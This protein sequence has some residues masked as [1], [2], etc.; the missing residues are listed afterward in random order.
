MCETGPEGEDGKD[1]KDGSI[2]YHGEG[3]P[4]DSLDDVYLF[5]LWINEDN[6]LVSSRL[7][8][9]ETA[10]IT[11]Y[12]WFTS[13]SGETLPYDHNLINGFIYDDLNVYPS[14]SIDNEEV[15]KQDYYETE[16]YKPTKE[17]MDYI[18]KGKILD[19]FYGLRD[20]SFLKQYYPEYFGDESSN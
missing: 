8:V 20:Y 2:F 1:G 15:H 17:E 18:F 3:K 6:P 4:G 16:P 11:T 13:V 12:N 10:C 19:N 14:I 5:N 7:L 9:K